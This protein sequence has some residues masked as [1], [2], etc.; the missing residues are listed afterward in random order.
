MAVVAVYLTSTCWS[1]Q[2]LFRKTVIGGAPARK[3]STH[4]LYTVQQVVLGRRPAVT[5][6]SR[7]CQTTLGCAFHRTRAAKARG[8]VTDLTALW[9]VKTSKRGDSPKGSAAPPRRR[10][11]LSD[12]GPKKSPAYRQP[13]TTAN[14]IGQTC[15][16]KTFNVHIFALAAKSLPNGRP[17]HVGPG[18]GP[19]IAVFSPHSEAMRTAKEPCIPV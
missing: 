16:C 18:N 6:C 17:R 9:T 7:K 2:Y 5:S 14:T 8:T 13:R 12:L 11:S 15:K 10:P 1:K 3:D 4:H 19:T